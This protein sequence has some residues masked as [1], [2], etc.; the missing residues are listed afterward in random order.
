MLDKKSRREN[1]KVNL[2]RQLKGLVKSEDN[3]INAVAFFLVGALLI[4]A[5][6]IA[7]TVF[8]GIVGGCCVLI[9]LERLLRRR[10]DK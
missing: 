7:E 2:K 5:G 9:G 3:L 10:G 1:M 8:A 6:F 4:A